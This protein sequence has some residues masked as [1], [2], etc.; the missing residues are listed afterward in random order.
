MPSVSRAEHNF[1][2]MIAHG[3]KSN[4]GKTPP[5]SVARDFVEADKGGDISTLPKHKGHAQA[6]ALRR[7]S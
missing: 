3:G 5:V 6:R 7:S 2:E 1:F 4:K